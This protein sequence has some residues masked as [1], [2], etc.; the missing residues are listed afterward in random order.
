M[1]PKETPVRERSV[2]PSP[3]EPMAGAL[4]E[5]ELSPDS[6]EIAEEINQTANSL[7][8]QLKELDRVTPESWSVLIE[9]RDQINALAN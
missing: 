9:L 8:K 7:L 3:S 5:P 4:S 6:H 2:T 1:R